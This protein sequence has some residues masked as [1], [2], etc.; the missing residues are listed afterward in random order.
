MHAERIEPGPGQESVW[1]YPRPPRVKATG[2]HLR[3][4]LAGKVVAESTRA[5]RVLKTSHPPTYYLPAEDV[6]LDLL[7]ASEKTSSCGFKGRAEYYCVEVGEVVK[8]SSAWSCP[9]P[10][11]AYTAIAGHVAFYP[12]A[13]DECTVDGVHVTPQGGDFCGGWI[14]PEIVGPFKGAPDTRGW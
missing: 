2:D 14:T 9:D 5:I 11:P 12:G 8:R 6:R 1:D 13:M 4:V 3:V 7:D 10:A